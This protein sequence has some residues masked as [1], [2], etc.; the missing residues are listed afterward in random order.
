MTAVYVDG[1]TASRSRRL[2]DPG[3]RP[4][5]GEAQ[6]AGHGH[7][8]IYCGEEVV[9]SP[10]SRQLGRLEALERL[11]RGSCRRRPW[12]CRC[13]SAGSPCRQSGPSAG[14]GDAGL[15]VK[16]S[17]LRGRYTRPIVNGSST[18]L[19]ASRPSGFAPGRSSSA[20]ATQSGVARLVVTAEWVR[21]KC[22]FGGCHAGQLPHVPAALADPIADAGAAGRVR[23]RPAAALR[24]RRS[25]RRRTPGGEPPHRRGRAPVGARV[26]PRRPLQGVRHRR[27]PPMR[28]RRGLRQRQRPATAGS[29]CAPGPRAAASTCSPPAPTP[30]WPLKVVQG[31]D[32]PYHRLALVLVD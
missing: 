11:G 12:P 15:A 16:R 32:E 5:Y 18:A 9:P 8:A 19:R 22:L 2:P 17:R 10:S 14:P 6:P 3:R 13:R 31:M 20:P 23:A 27:R 28:P 1:V 25:A 26:V 30:G 24:C 21:M 7:A 29:R 4:V